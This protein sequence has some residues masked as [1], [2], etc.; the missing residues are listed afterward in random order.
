MYFQKWTFPWGSQMTGILIP[1]GHSTR[2]IHNEP[3]TFIHRD[4][5][6][7]LSHMPLGSWGSGCYWVFSLISLQGGRD[8]HPSC[9]KCSAICQEENI[10]LA[11]FLSASCYNMSL[12][13]WS[14]MNWHMLYN[15]GYD[16]N[17]SL[18]KSI[19]FPFLSASILVFYSISSRVLQ[20]NLFSLDSFFW[21]SPK[22]SFF[23]KF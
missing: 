6:V 19:F 18:F 11:S 20:W 4:W 22:F 21:T 2:G 1:N 8:C 16:V 23:F 3:G 17:F 12:L 10:R 13:S 15:N 9:I 5:L 14:E 7:F